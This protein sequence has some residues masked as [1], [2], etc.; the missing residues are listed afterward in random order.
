MKRIAPLIDRRLYNVGD[1]IVQEGEIGTSFYL[2]EEGAVEVF[3]QTDKGETILGH[4]GKTGI[5][6]E[7]AL[8]DDG[9]RMA[10]VRAIRPTT[11]RIF[12]REYF[13]YRLARSDKLIGALMRIF[14]AHIRSLTHLQA[15]V[16]VKGIQ[17]P[18]LKLSKDDLPEG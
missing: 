18:M 2:I 11:C 9:M 4:I 17:R 3:K 13:Q 12:P 6:G 8:V 1:I 14:T 5:F 7:M 10:S 16:G 15:E